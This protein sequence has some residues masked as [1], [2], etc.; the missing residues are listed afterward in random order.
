MPPAETAPGRQGS[1]DRA[2]R[3]V[4]VWFRRDLRVADNPALAAAVAAGRPVI[5][6]FILD[7]GRGTPSLGG[8]SKWW[9]D[10][11]LAALAR[12]LASLGSPLVLRRGRAE[13]ELIDLVQETGAAAVLMNRLFEP[14]EWARDAEIAHELKTSGV[15]CRGFN[16]T[17]L[18]TPGA[19]LTG[20]GRPFKVFTPFLKALLA[21]AGPPVLPAAPPRLAPGPNVR[22]EDLASWRLGPAS[23]D[24]STGFDWTPGEAGAAQALSVFVANGLADYSRGRDRPAANAC[25]RLS[26]HL[27]WGEIHPWRIVGTVRAAAAATP[28]LKPEADKFVAE[29]AWREFSAH[30]LHHFP[31]LPER[32]FHPRYDAMEWRQDEDGFAAWTRGRTGYPIVD[33]GMRQLWTTGWM[34]NRVRMIA[35]S[36]L[37][38]DLLI[39]WRRGQEWFRDT[40]VDADLASNSQNW[41]WVAGSGADASPFFRVLNPTTQGEKFDPDGDYV[42][43]WAPELARLPSKWIHAPFAAP[44]QVLKDAGVRLGETYPKPIV[45]HAAARLRALAALKA[46]NGDR[47][48]ADARARATPSFVRR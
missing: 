12:Q 15:D 46:V 21:Q 43:R 39:D 38:K 34:H 47:P 32:S 37:V 10:R 1:G 27:H 26:P 33:A 40:L 11:S 48:A 9:L 31:H 16:G 42:R 6:L 36:F 20:A 19:V 18:S 4:I 23:P 5:P 25:S 35:A 7:E 29:I 14:A 3:P 2:G 41:Q 8:A 44:A 24:W 17:L 45:D 28:A 13:L 22:S 30:L